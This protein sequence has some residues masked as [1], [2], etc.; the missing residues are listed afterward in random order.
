[1]DVASPPAE[2]GGDD[3]HSTRQQIDS[4]TGKEDDSP[5]S[6][7]EVTDEHGDDGMSHKDA[8]LKLQNGLSKI[9]Q[10]LNSKLF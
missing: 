5:A 1:M 10:V 9:I 4:E 8:M 2:E 6:D 3:Q 7:C